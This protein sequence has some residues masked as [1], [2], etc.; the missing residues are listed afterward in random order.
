MDIHGQEIADD[1]FGDLTDFDG[2]YPAEGAIVKLRNLIAI[3]QKK[4]KPMKRHQVL[5][6]VIKAFN[7]WMAGVDLPKRWVM[8]VNDDFPVFNQKVDV[9]GG[10]GASS[11]AAAG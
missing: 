1:F 5:G 11:P 4:E 2:N 3:D 10:A 9:D 7:A 6:N 8:A